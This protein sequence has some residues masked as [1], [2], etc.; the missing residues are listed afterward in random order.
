MG[1]KVSDGFFPFEFAEINHLQITFVI[2]LIFQ[3]AKNQYKILSQI[4]KLHW[5]S[6]RFVIVVKWK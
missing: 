1:S 2:I 3:R 4:I 6:K 5:A